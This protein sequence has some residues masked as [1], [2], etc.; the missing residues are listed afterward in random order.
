MK[1]IFLAGALWF[2]FFNWNNFLPAPKPAPAPTPPPVVQ[3]CVGTSPHPYDLCWKGQWWINATYFGQPG[4]T[5]FTSQN[6]SVDSQNNLHIKIAQVNGQWSGAQLESE[7]SFGYGTYTWKVTS[8]V[9]F[10]PN[11]ASGLF[12]YNQPDPAFAHREID[13]IEG[14]KWGNAADTTNAQFTIQ[15][16]D[17]IGNLHR[18]VTNT[19]PS[20]ISFTWTATSITFRYNDQTWVYNGTIPT[21]SAQVFMN[22]WL[23][24][25][26]APV[27]GQPHEL[28]ISDFQYTP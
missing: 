26:N 21:P 20:T 27:D 17:T 7:N 15:P 24:N 2:N 5:N 28:V 12:T 11:V 1:V 9:Y 10:D 16:F 4:P 25:G 6:V 18:L 19:Q 14:A 3:A 22:M 13:A 23:F 8:P